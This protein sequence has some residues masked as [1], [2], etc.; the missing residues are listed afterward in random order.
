MLKEQL[1]IILPEHAWTYKYIKELGYDLHSPYYGTHFIPRVFR[2]I[3]FRLNLPGKKCWYKKLPQKDYEVI[4]LYEALITK[5]YLRWVQKRYLTKRIIILYTNPVSKRNSSI[6][7]QSNVEYWSCDEVDSKKYN[8][9]LL[10]CGG[11][12][13]QWKIQKSQPE[14]DVFYIGKD[15]NRLNKLQEIENQL[16][17]NGVKTFFYITWE[18]SWQKKQDGIHKPFLPYEGVLNYLGKSRAILHL[19]EGAQH[20]ITIRIQE[21]LIH[22]IK[23]IT[24]DRSIEKYDFYNPNNI[25]ILGKDDL[26]GLRSFLDT[27]YK[28]ITSSFLEHAF[29]DQL[30]DAFLCNSA[31]NND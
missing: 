1:L 16:N 29:Y 7:N 31:L 13:P 20:G 15:K 12:F 27:P 17:A 25:F 8:M 21:S 3:F 10:T 23:L 4:I 22:K 28:P 18:R 11:Y 9:N 5:D 6:L 26:T 14:I 24:D 19:A 30:I 2:E